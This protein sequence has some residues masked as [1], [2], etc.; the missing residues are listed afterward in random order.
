MGQYTAQTPCSPHLL[1][2]VSCDGARVQ[3]EARM[4]AL[5]TYAEAR[6][7]RLR[8][9][10]LGGGE[11]ASWSTRRTGSLQ[12]LRSRS[13][14]VEDRK[15]TEGSVP[16][17]G[18]C[19]CAVISDVFGSGT[20]TQ[21]AWSVLCSL[22]CLSC[23][24]SCSLGSL[25]LPEHQPSSSLGAQATHLTDKL[26]ATLHIGPHPAP[27]RYFCLATGRHGHRATGAPACPAGAVF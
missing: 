24:C 20:C 5:G 22:F 3:A 15:V 27:A 23:P 4:W 2:V 7:G 26:D 13:R 6:V 8:L 21:S 16:Q 18:T 12:C 9:Q 11:V 25:D 19:V 10:G 14:G 17:A 1:T